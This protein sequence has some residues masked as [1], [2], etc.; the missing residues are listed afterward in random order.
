M[1]KPYIPPLPNE[2]EQV[3][4][5]SIL[6]RLFE[7]Q[8]PE[9][10]PSQRIIDNP[11]WI[12][13][14][15]LV[16][17]L[18]D[19][20]AKQKEEALIEIVS[21]GKYGIIDEITPVIVEFTRR[22]NKEM[23]RQV[24]V[25]KL[26][27]FEALSLTDDNIGFIYNSRYFN[28]VLNDEIR[29]AI[30]YKTPVSIAIWD[31]DYFKRINDTY[32]HVGGNAVLEE[33]AKRAYN[34]LRDQ[35]IFARTGG[36]EF[37]VIFPRTDLKKAGELCIDVKKVIE[38]A[39]INY[40]LNGVNNEIMIKLSVGFDQYRGVGKKDELIKTVDSYLY[41][42]KNRGRNKIVGPGVIYDSITKKWSDIP[43]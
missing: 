41:Q 16:N 11:L 20:S 22:V 27:H 36:D 39:P 10:E 12:L 34:V 31:V 37:S 40:E 8:I 9:L 4:L 15:T 23:K 14:Q 1:P 7:I 13:E 29:E 35:D 18:K 32:L 26:A 19:K 2:A 17:G 33:L 25:E 28:Q 30:R 6:K 42:A 21:P 24:E 38:S 3:D 43:I 5:D